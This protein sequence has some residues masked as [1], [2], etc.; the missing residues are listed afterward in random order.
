VKNRRKNGDHYWVVANAT[1]LLEGGK[2]RG[3]MSVRTRPTREQVAFAEA[4]YR[5]FPRG[6]RQGL[7]IHEGG[8][9]QQ[10]LLAC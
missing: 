4:A 7:A 2:V 1:P 5:R 3:H 9:V 8:V 6:P 10:R